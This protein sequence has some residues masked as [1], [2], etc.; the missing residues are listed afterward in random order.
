MELSLKTHLEVDRSPGQV[1]SAKLFRNVKS[2]TSR[3]I[4]EQTVQTIIYF[5]LPTLFTLFSNGFFS[6]VIENNRITLIIIVTNM[7]LLNR[8]IY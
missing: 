4:K 8:R 2:D 7:L 1:C 3:I 5:I 6:Y